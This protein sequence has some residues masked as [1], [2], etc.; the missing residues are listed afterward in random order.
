MVGS[1]TLKRVER[2]MREETSLKDS[3]D[4]PRSGRN[5]RGNNNVIDYEMQ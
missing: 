1:G 5:Y 3:L 4:R 2:R